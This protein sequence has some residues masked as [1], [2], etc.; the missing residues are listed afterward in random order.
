MM[1]SVGLCG[2]VLWRVV[3]IR[4]MLRWSKGAIPNGETSA[5]SRAT[6]NNGGDRHL[7]ELE[8]NHNYLRRIHDQ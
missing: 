3:V 1:Y 8:A 5:T 2:H 6:T 7:P 4:L